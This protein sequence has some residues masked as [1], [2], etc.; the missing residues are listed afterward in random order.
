MGVPD[1]RC[2]PRLGETKASSSRA[3]ATP[4]RGSSMLSTP[5]PSQVA[6]LSSGSTIRS[7]METL[8][9]TNARK[10]ATDP[11]CCRR[12]GRAKWP[13]PR[14]GAPSGWC[15][16]RYLRRMHG[17]TPRIL[18]AVDA[19]AGPSGLRLEREPLHGAPEDV[20]YDA[21]TKRS[22]GSSMLS[23]EKPGQMRHS[24]SGSHFSSVG[25]TP[26]N[27]QKPAAKNNKAKPVDFVSEFAI[28]F[29]NP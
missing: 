25:N 13:T 18:D 8:F 11:R 1:P 17:R 23:P 2:C 14:A 20:I 3:P 15:R 7:V 27:P 24:S 16:A 21:S 26:R 4:R 28:F 9:T 5:R 10:N 12:P 19:R 6:Q 29:A 22:H